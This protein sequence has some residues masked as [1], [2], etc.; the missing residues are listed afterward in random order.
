MAGPTT[1]I[2]FASRKLPPSTCSRGWALGRIGE[3]TAVSRIRRTQ[4]IQEVT[5]G[6]DEDQLRVRKEPRGHQRT[7]RRSTSSTEGTARTPEDTRGHDI[8]P[9]RDRE[10]PGSN[11][12]PP[13]KNRIQID[14]FAC[15]VWSAGVTGR[16]QIFL[17]LGGGSRV[18]VD[19]EPSSELAH[20]Y[21]TADISARARPQ[22]REAPGFENQRRCL[23][24]AQI[25]TV[26]GLTQLH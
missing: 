17:G 23:R 9:V 15:S 21:R 26:G 7:R 13:T 4:R 2:R 10:A 1:S 3:V 18:Q 12:W 8:T 16:S 14:D 24:G 20:G 19:L 25:R 5:G 22:D 11:P 6:H